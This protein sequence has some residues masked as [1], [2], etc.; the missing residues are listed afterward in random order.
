MLK[1]KF[2]GR[3]LKTISDEACNIEFQEN[4]WQGLYIEFTKMAIYDWYVLLINMAKN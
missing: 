2:G 4:L 1:L 3:H